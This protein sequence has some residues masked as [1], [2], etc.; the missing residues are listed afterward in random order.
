M[1]NSI[2][3]LKKTLYISLSNSIVDY[4]NQCSVHCNAE[5]SGRCEKVKS[6][7]MINLLLT[8]LLLSWLNWESTKEL[9]V[10]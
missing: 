3:V 7:P 8:E 9:S 1:N 2:R 5:E 4:G 6:P 10:A